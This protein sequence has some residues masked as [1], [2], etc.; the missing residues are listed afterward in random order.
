MGVLQ[1][2]SLLAFLL[3]APAPL[4]LLV[5]GSPEAAVEA[6]RLKVQRIALVHDSAVKDMPPRVRQYIGYRLKDPQIPPAV[7]LV[8]GQSSLALRPRLILVPTRDDST[9]SAACGSSLCLKA[10]GKTIQGRGK[11]AAWFASAV[12]QSG[13]EPRALLADP[14]RLAALQRAIVET[15]RI[16]L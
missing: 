1:S 6:A 13:L 7:T 12:L 4:D 9:N 10:E 15:G 8:R 2:V 3:Q 16:A 11:L 5:I 14:V